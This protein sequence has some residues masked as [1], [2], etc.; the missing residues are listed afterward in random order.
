MNESFEAPAPPGPATLARLRA[1]FAH[2]PKGAAPSS[3]DPDRIWAAV[4]GAPDSDDD[5]ASRLALLDQLNSDPQLALEWRLAAALGPIPAE[6]E[7]A[8]LQL[9]SNAPQSVGRDGSSSLPIAIGVM[10][11]AAAALALW[12]SS[13]TPTEPPG[14]TPTRDPAWRAQGPHQLLHTTLGVDDPLTRSEFRLQWSSDVEGASS[15]TV[16]VT[17]Q[18]LA[19]VYEERAL[20]S[21]TALVPATALESFPPGTVLLWRVEAVEPDGRSHA[22]RVWEITV[23]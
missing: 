19:P 16:R 23:E 22:S 21:T 4:H 12:F 13:T 18:D 2:V 8:D 7:H 11:A 6:H 14:S 9:A 10:V 17:T 20:T 1:G 15:F 3:T 5:D